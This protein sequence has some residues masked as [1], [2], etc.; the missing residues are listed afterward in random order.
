VSPEN[1]EIMRRAFDAFNRQD[2]EAGQAVL[3]ADV[4]WEV[5]IGGPDDGLYRG[6]A[7]V[8]Q[9]F[10]AWTAVLDDIRY[11]VDELTD[12]GDDVFAAVVA[13]AR[14]RKSRLETRRQF[15]AVYTFRDRLIVRVRVF[16]ER[17]Q[18]L[19][20]AGLRA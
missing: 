12:A 13:V 9:W 11:D 19:E 5:A 1:V 6:R 2:A 8:R 7:G 15:F 17:Q 3:A 16:S 4:L 18:A 10:R 14:G 20:A